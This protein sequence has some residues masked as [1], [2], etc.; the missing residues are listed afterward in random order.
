[1]L[2]VMR[3]RSVGQLALNGTRPP[4]WSGLVDRSAR[5]SRGFS[6]R[7]ESVWV[8][9]SWLVS[10]RTRSRGRR[11]AADPEAEPPLSGLEGAPAGRCQGPR[12]APAHGSHGPK[13]SV[14]QL[15]LMVNFTRLE[16]CLR[17]RF[18]RTCAMASQPALAASTPASGT[19]PPAKT[20]QPAPVDRSLRRGD[21]LAMG[22]PL[23]AAF[24]GLLLLRTNALASDEK[25]AETSGEA[26]AAGLRD[27]PDA[28]G[29]ALTQAIATSP[30]G[31]TATRADG[32][33]DV[34]FDQ[35]GTSGSALFIADGGEVVAADLDAV[36]LTTPI[37]PSAVETGDINLS[38][39][40][41]AA[42]T[43]YTLADPASEITDGEE[44]IWWNNPTGEWI[45]GKDLPSNV[46]V[47][48]D[49]DDVL[50]GTDEDNIIYGLAG[51]DYIIT[52][53]G[54]N[55]VFAGPGNDIIFV[56]DQSIITKVYGNNQLFGEA[57]Y[58]RIFGGPGNDTLDGGEGW[59]WLYG[60]RGDDR[61]L[62]DAKV[63]GFD[64]IT[65]PYGF[66]SL[67]LINADEHEF[68]FHWLQPPDGIPTKPTLLV[69][70]D[71][72]GRALVVDYDLVT[73]HFRLEIDGVHYRIPD[74]KGGYLNHAPAAQTTLDVVTGRELESFAYQL[75]ADLFRDIDPGDRFTLSLA[76][77]SG[78]PVPAWLKFDPTTGRLSG[79]PGFGDQGTLDLVVR[80][81]DSGGAVG[82]TP[83]VLH[84][85]DGNRPPEI[86]KALDDHVVTPGDA[87]TW[88]LPQNAFLD[89]DMQY[90]DSLRFEVAGLPHWLAFDWNTQTF[91]TRG[92]LIPREAGEANH[93]ITVRAI[94][95]HGAWVENTFTIEV[96]P[97]PNA[98]PEATTTESY[99][100]LV[101]GEL[102]TQSWVL[103]LDV[104]A[105][106]D[107]DAFT[108]IV[109]LANDQALPDWLSFDATTNTLTAAPGVAQ[110]DLGELTLWVRAHDGELTS[111]TPAT[112]TL[113]VE[114]LP[115]FIDGLEDARI[116]QDAPLALQL[117]GNFGA[118]T[119]VTL[120]AAMLDGDPW[121]GWLSFDATT[122]LFSGTPGNADV[123]TYEIAVTYASDAGHAG[124]LT[125]Q[126]AV[127]N[128]NDAPF[129]VEGVSLDTAITGGDAFVIDTRQA[130]D[131]PDFIHG[132]WLTYSFR[133]AE[134]LHLP[135]WFPQFSASNGIVQAT[136]GK[137]FTNESYS[138]VVRAT[139]QSGEWAETTFTLDVAGVNTAP[140]Q[141]FFPDAPS[142]PQGQ[143]L[144]W[145]VDLGW[146]FHD[147]DLE[148]GDVLT[149]GAAAADGWTWP[150][151]LSFDA[152]TGLFS[153]TPGNADVGAHHVV[154]TATDL[155]GTS[156]TSAPLT[157]HVANVNDAPF[158]QREVPTQTVEGGVE[159]SFFLPAGA[160]GNA[161]R[162]IFDDPDFIHAHWN[163]RLT[164]S[165]QNA[166]AWLD[167][168]HHMGLLTVAAD[169]PVGSHEITLRATDSRGA[170]AETTFTI[171][172]GAPNAP[173]EATT[174]ES[175]ADLVVGELTTQSWVL[176][177]D[178]FA[179]PD[180]DA[181]TLIV[182]LA[183]DQALPDWL[184]FDATTNTLTAA[185]GVAQA[186][187][188]ELTLWVRAHDGEL[189]STTPATFTL[190]VEALPPFI[191]GL[192]DA[193]I[194]Q[195]A[196]LA[197]QLTG[198]FGAFT[199]VTLA[200]AMLDGDPWPGWLSFDATTGLFS[201]TPGNA[202]VGTYE[203][204]VTYASDEGH[205]G[206]LTFQ[207][208]VDN[209]NDA[210]F[211]AGSM[212]DQDL[213]AG[214]GAYF[215]LP[216]G[217]FDDPDFL[218]PH[219]NESLTLTASGLPNW[220]SFNPATGAF[221]TMLDGPPLA[222]V[223]E[224]HEITLRATDSHGASAETTFSLNVLPS[225]NSA[226]I[227][228]EDL[229]DQS[230]T[231][232]TPWVMALPAGLFVDP[233]G[234]RFEL[235][236]TVDGGPRPAWL[237]FDRD[238]ETLIGQP[239]EPGAFVVQVVATDS[240]GA[241]SAPIS[242]RLTV[243][244]PI[245]ENTPPE[246]DHGAALPAA[247]AGALWS[248]DLNGLFSDP[249]GDA[250]A[251]TVTVDGQNL[252]DVAW[253]SL[254][255]DGILSGTPPDAA[256]HH[257]T[258][259]ADDGRGGTVS[260]DWS[261]AVAPADLPDDPAPGWEPPVFDDFTHPITF[262]ANG[263]PSNVNFGGSPTHL[264]SSSLA[265]IFEPHRDFYFHNWHSIPH[266]EHGDYGTMMFQ[267][268]YTP[269]RAV[270]GG[271]Y[272]AAVFTRDD[273]SIIY[274]NQHDM[275]IHGGAGNDILW[276]GTAGNNVLV[277]NAG[278]DVL[279]GGAGNDLLVGGSGYNVLYGG[280]GDDRY[281]IGLHED[282]SAFDTIY[283]HDGLNTLEFDGVAMSQ[284]AFGMSGA[285]AVIAV[286]GAARVRIV[287]DQD[288]GLGD[289]TVETTDG[290]QSL[291]ALLGAVQEHQAS[292]AAEPLFAEAAGDDLL[293]PFM[294]TALEA[295]VNTGP[296]DV[297]AGYL[298]Q[299]DAIAPTSSASATFL[300]ETGLASGYLFPDDLSSTS[301][302]AAA[303][304]A[305]KPY[306][307]DENPYG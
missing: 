200:A 105:D 94:D 207:L 211:V 90:G 249:D 120:A 303:G 253:L 210:P 67:V 87:F 44:H 271:N 50:I 126:L 162:Y 130:F 151:W 280:L 238:T 119:G 116:D 11:P 254:G 20:G 219:W 63:A 222:A 196:P 107:G 237:H 16:V 117:T 194:D 103:P 8:P 24:I 100:N 22:A 255:A 144:H 113:T 57:G 68:T 52:R 297:L 64:F 214:S 69:A 49:G 38:L 53:A 204:A 277:G 70:V 123:G 43:D 197:L 109:S 285:D 239:P 75:P 225:G 3:V 128:V 59:N 263:T 292:A 266:Y 260:H 25:P 276:G 66:N 98:P 175:Y 34:V 2:L 295:D 278:N 93:T 101:V 79:Q 1:M 36:T 167:F 166:P 251:F 287:A 289:F 142:T 234:D 232:D 265:S 81:T 26:A 156:A 240:H 281:L 127:D 275:F 181:F 85:F 125:F 195:D 21:T 28:G 294:A 231:V 124:T 83:L 246:V 284:L 155:A 99:A 174:P 118:F 273:D 302:A 152:T 138:V 137:Q 121:P 108:L 27:Q 60:E 279:I 54:N 74:G 14:V 122:G 180:G 172:I 84:V 10:T 58:D 133:A 170:R 80:A 51:D 236:V 212:P 150:A 244:D 48:T 301:E 258:V 242:F 261:L 186:D 243:N 104:F 224:T 132:D 86:G 259:T 147:P 190:T 115:P 149:F 129:V 228:A 95:S 171:E 230:V 12:D 282:G 201:G 143:A 235:T 55:I 296:E 139:D 241:V 304:L 4:S 202:D 23:T 56:I 233:E 182:S 42:W 88:Q 270:I 19:R 215:A 37:A 250:L 245:P 247:T 226:P 298:D 78:E 193:R 163:E 114:A 17:T 290:S 46:I 177:L 111:T 29:G 112:F 264:I 169:A 89:P 189:T 97:A 110:A 187:L 300:A 141:L 39:A 178:V 18:A 205:A 185:P 92:E 146:M 192:E 35:P 220:L 257:L 62:I 179:D 106:P 274:G 15:Q 221:V 5:R 168:N 217:L 291:A 272:K 135:H 72:V 45:D 96:L 176:P 191:D 161:A 102:T 32:V 188:G 148:H 184:S 160:D 203:I 293:A 173:P 216:S 31:T 262:N 157:F 6:W 252:A 91:F 305:S 30:D 206:T 223:G 47:G 209:V 208:A 218:H 41:E 136:A 77:R 198:N 248:L 268:A 229:A 140:E 267:D 134:G 165:V 158:V 7:I 71:G 288:G 61:Y 145:S 159:H 283:D 40:G 131:D 199:G 82:E 269:L 307:Q 306:H 13:A 164:L 227:A 183:N 154:I 33:G 65:D 299:P 76:T 9:R 73:T 153:G 256:D 213:V 286:D